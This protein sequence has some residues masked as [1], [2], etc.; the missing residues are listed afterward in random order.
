MTNIRVQG[1]MVNKW[2]MEM[3]WKGLYNWR[4]PP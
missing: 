1:W 4:N 2:T 3:D